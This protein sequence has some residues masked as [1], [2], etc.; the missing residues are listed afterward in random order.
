MSAR[1][2]TLIAAAAAFACVEANFAFAEPTPDSAF[3]GPTPDSVYTTTVQLPDGKTLSCA[4][5]QLLPPGVGGAALSTTE[6][7]QADVLATQPLR[8][9]SGPTSAY[10]TSYTAP[11]VICAP[12]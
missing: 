6:Q 3:D 4:V 12:A 5:N 1:S 9:L 11:H 10:P 2:L 8:L 7:R